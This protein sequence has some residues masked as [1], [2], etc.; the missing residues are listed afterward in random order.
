M[1]ESKRLTLPDVGDA[2][3]Q[4]RDRADFGGEIP[5]ASGLEEG[6]EL[7]RHVEM[8]FDRVFAAARDDDDVL[9]AG[10]G[11]FFDAVLDDRLVDERQHLLWLRFGCRQKPRAEAGGGKHGLSYG[12]CHGFAP[13]G[14]VSQTVAAGCESALWHRAV[15]G[16][17][18][19]STFATGAQGPR[20]S[21]KHAR[22]G[23]HQGASG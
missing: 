6:L 9:D 5:L 22:S 14:I 18:T 4:I 2:L 16:P 7:D 13:R 11:G 20:Y 1:A 17:Q 12:R 15:M 21:M 8:I 3:D 23:V 10:G 19:Q